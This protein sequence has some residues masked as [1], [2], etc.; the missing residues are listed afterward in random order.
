MR[1]ARR[2]LAESPARFAKATYRVHLVSQGFEAD[3]GRGVTAEAAQLVSNMPYLVGYKPDGELGYLS[4]NGERT[5][6]LIAID[7]KAQRTEVSGLVLTRLETRFV[8][9]LMRQA[10]GTYKYESRRKETSLGDTPLTI[11]ATRL[12]AEAGHRGA[13]QLRVRGE[14]RVRRQ[15][16]AR[17]DY[18]VAGE[19]NVTR[20]LEKNAELS[21]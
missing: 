7:P 15:Q 14:R 16:L 4:R 10:N 6:S 20:T 9:V 5:V 19:G 1:K 8:S 18:Q 21:S 17:F 11:P 3:G 13:G 2:R 12:F